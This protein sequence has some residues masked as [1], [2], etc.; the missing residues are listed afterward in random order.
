ML[1]YAI[2]KESKT[3]SEWEEMNKMGAEANDEFQ[4]SK[5]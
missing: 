5:K 2:S 3:K 4:I 1:R